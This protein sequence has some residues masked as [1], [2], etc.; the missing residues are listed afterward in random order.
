MLGWLF[1]PSCPCDL[2]AKAWV[3]ERLQWLSEEFDDNVF[4]GRPIVLPTPEFF[5]DAYDGSETAVQMLLDRVC[6]YMDA[7]PDLVEL[8]FKAN[9]G[10]LG[11]VDENGVAL[12]DTMGTFEEG[13]RQYRITVDT[14]S[15]DDPMALV[16]TMAHE[17]AHVRLL[18]EGR[19]SREEYDNEL[20]T[21]LTT[22][23]FGM[24]IFLANAATMW[25][26]NF[27]KKWPGTNLRKPEYMSLPMY[28][29]ALAHLAWFCGEEAP[30][31]AKYLRSNA[32]SEFKQAVRY[33]FKT[34]ASAYRP[35]KF[36]RRS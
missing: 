5:P 20:L 28:A 32:R 31:W 25:E 27:R 4:N 19:C 24:G 30:A 15:L 34:G 22:V 9:A 35:A 23:H 3:E 8:K 2:Q 7:V 26:G 16:G 10:K 33:L 17:L 14:Y 18:G 12:G 1:P 13:R 29:H 36:R 6:E 11:W 21:D